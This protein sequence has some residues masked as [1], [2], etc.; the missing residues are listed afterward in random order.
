[1]TS[2]LIP[3][4]LQYSIQL[5]DWKT[6]DEVAKDDFVFANPTNA[7]KIKINELKSEIGDLPGHFTVGDAQ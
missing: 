3:S 7:E 1:M 5:T 2:K 4:G 6:G